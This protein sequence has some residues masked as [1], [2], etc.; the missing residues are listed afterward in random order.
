MNKEERIKKKLK[1]KDD[2]K[3]SHEG[4]QELEIK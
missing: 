2:D 1:V 4:E 3:N